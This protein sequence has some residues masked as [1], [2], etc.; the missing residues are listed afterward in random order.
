VLEAMSA[1]VPVVAADRGSLPEVL[2]GA[3]VP[4]NPDRPQEIAAGM[5]R[6]LED[7]AYAA[8]CFGRGIA[9]AREFRWDRTV[10]RVRAAYEHAIARRRHRSRAA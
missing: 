3:G 7:P 8:E 9:R 2:G 5:A 1:G 10:E 4:V 6:L